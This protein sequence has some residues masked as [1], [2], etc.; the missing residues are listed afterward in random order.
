MGLSSPTPDPNQDEILG[1]NITFSPC[2]IKGSSW[3]I[4][5]L[6]FTNIIRFVSKLATETAGF[7]NI[8]SRD[9]YRPDLF[10]SFWRPDYQKW[11]VNISSRDLRCEY[12]IPPYEYYVQSN[13]YLWY[14]TTV[15]VKKN[16]NFCLWHN[17]STN[18]CVKIFKNTLWHIVRPAECHKV[19]KN[20]QK[21]HHHYKNCA[22]KKQQF[23]LNRLI[24]GPSR[25]PPLG[26]IFA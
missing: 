25:Q 12:F 3:P 1:W 14:M 18:S 4:I 26:L 24:L 2:K 16:V 8:G 21:W 23:Y 9:H 7:A 20:E 17:S 19:I 10:C 15:Y 5:I 13:S 11:S 22:T 6:L